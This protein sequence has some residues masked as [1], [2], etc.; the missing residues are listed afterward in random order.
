VRV[1]PQDSISIVAGG[2][3]KVAP[4]SPHHAGA[5]GA[6][7]SAMPV[8]ELVGSGHSFQGGRAGAG[9]RLVYQRF[10]G[11]VPS[12]WH[13][14]HARRPK[15]ANFDRVEWQVSPIRHIGAALQRGEIDW[16]DQRS[17]IFS[18]PCAPNKPR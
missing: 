17:S 4:S 16:W 6:A 7:D 8:K 11:Y 3:R 13:G 9:A 1:A 5:I 18:R 2:A 14:E 15:F 12:G 10:D